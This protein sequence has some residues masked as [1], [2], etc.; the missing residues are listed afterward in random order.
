MLHHWQG[1]SITYPEAFSTQPPPSSAPVWV[2]GQT[3]PLR[4]QWPGS[5]DPTPHRSPRIPLHRSFWS[6]TNV[7]F[8]CNYTPKYAC[9][10]M[11]VSFWDFSSFSSTYHFPSVSDH[12]CHWQDVS[13]LYSSTHPECSQLQPAPGI[14]DASPL[15]QTE[16]RFCKFGSFFC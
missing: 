2:V 11:I 14:S 6:E 13:V 5:T 9:E 15:L 12:V 1:D 4:Q 10:E 16:C 3:P 7:S 8:Y